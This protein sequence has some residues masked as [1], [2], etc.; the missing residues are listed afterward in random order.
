M[1]DKGQSSQ[2]E[3]QQKLMLYQ[4]MGQRLE[5][6]N[7][8]ARA[9]EQSLLEVE[10]TRQALEGLKGVKEGNDVLVP[11][12]SG[13]YT[14]GK[15]SDSKK[16][17]CD[18]GAGIMADKSPQEALKVID[19]KRAEIDRFSDGL[20]KEARSVVNRMNEL[21]PELQRILQQAQAG[22]EKPGKSEKAG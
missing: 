17:L 6:I 3:A 14:Y 4:I 15:A 21:A 12:G 11:L 22:P 20:Q 16:L 7:E 9:L 10:T 2:Q 18:L 5:Q 13:C 8:Q 1:P 19:E